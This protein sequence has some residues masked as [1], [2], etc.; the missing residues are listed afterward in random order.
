MS[1]IG[2]AL[3]SWG[4]ELGSIFLDGISA[5]VQGCD[6]AHAIWTFGSED[7]LETFHV[8]CGHTTV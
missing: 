1:Q 6:L 7:L 2:V 8:L 4:K 5:E 3:K